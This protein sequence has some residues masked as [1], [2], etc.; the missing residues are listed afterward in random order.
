MAWYSKYLS[1]YDKDFSEVNDKTVDKIRR[2]VASKQCDHPEVSVVVI[3]HNEARRIAACLW[4]LAEME[5]GCDMEIMVVDNS[6]DDGTADVVRALGVTC[7]HES[8]K[9]PGYARQCG[10]D[11]AHGR[12]HF[13]IDADTFYPKHYVR[14]MLRRLKTDGVACVGALWSFYPDADHSQ[15]S[16]WVYEAVRDIFLFVQ[17]FKRPELCIRGMTFAFDMEKAAGLRVRTDIIRGEDGSFALELK[18]RGRIAFLV[19]RRARPVTGHGT[20]GGGSLLSRLTRS[21]KVQLKGIRRIFFKTD[22]YDDNPD[23]LINNRS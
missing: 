19:D 6:S 3:A 7:C 8:R 9:S 17:H 4:S 2:A 10:I 15:L 11:H 20:V 21:A 23:N 18:S 22:K 16:L 12:Y 14:L 5:P 13:F 1:I